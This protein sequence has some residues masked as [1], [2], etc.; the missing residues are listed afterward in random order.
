MGNDGVQ[1]QALLQKNKIMLIMLSISVVLATI[2]EF[3]IDAAWKNIVTI[4]IGGLILIAVVAIAHFKKVFVKV[5][6]FIAIIGL[7]AIL[8]TIMHFS[9]SDQNVFIVY[10]LIAC[11][12]L[13]LEY[14]IYFVGSILAIGL[15]GS[16]YFMYGEQL[17]TEITNTLL[18]L[19]LVL[20]VFFLQMK[21]TKKLANNIEALTKEN[22]LRFEDEQANRQGLQ[23]K[24][25]QIANE[26]Q[27]ISESSE[28]NHHSFEEMNK[29]V[30]EVASG[31]QTQSDS[32]NDITNSIENSTKMIKQMLESTEVIISETGRAGESSE[33]GRLKIQQLQKQIHSFKSLVTEMAKNMDTLSKH[34]GD[35]VSS[36]HSIKEITSQ[37]NLLA[38][39]ASIEASRAGEA[40]RGFAVVADEIRKLAEL[41]EK[42]TEVISNNLAEI[43]ESNDKS[44]IQMTSIAKEMDE[45]IRETEETTSIFENINHAIQN[46]GEEMKQFKV[47]AINIGEDTSAIEIAINEFAA[48]VEEATATIEEISA[49]VQ[50]HTDQNQDVVKQIEHINL[51]VI[52]LTK[53]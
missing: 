12:V 42:T 16:Y 27:V 30:Q 43:S 4:L 32:V 15:V 10:Y 29:A 7:A 18:I 33:L 49:S 9:I 26:L 37:T 53:E 14:K 48:V 39:N 38:L 28:M 50:H 31:T 34:V 25:K 41:T 2:V 21:I 8:G 46:L 1:Y 22:Q 23:A 35:S 24:T 6:P 20:I 36:L 5:T 3:S 44:Q 13:Y 19:G 40:G 45:N 51:A 47:L 52:A 17:Q 11:S